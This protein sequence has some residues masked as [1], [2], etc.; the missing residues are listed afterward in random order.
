MPYQPSPIIEA[1][2]A[3]LKL[4]PEDGE[5]YLAELNALHT[6]EIN[7]AA[8]QIDGWERAAG[9]TAEAMAVAQARLGERETELD[10]MRAWLSELCSL[11][12]IEEPDFTTPVPEGWGQMLDVEPERPVTADLSA[13]SLMAMK[14]ITLV[15]YIQWLRERVKLPEEDVRALAAHNAELR[16]L[17]SRL[18]SIKR[19]RHFDAEVKRLLDS[20]IGGRQVRLIHEDAPG[21]PRDPETAASVMPPGDEAPE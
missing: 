3:S 11:V 16:M 19:D 6:A 9:E 2:R 1:L 15:K 12:E 5:V 20:V 13:P 4:D 14:R 17:W 7:D 10:R 21:H 8:G 18:L